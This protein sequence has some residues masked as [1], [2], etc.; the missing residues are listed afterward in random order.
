MSRKRASFLSQS[1]IPFDFLF[2]K[3]KSRTDKCSGLEIK[4][5]DSKGPLVRIA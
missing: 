2:D 4:T 3:E 1:G 5:V